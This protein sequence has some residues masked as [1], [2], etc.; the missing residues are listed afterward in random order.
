MLEIEIIL[1]EGINDKRN[2]HQCILPY[3]LYVCDNDSSC[4]LFLYIG[5]NEYKDTIQCII[6]DTLN[7]CD[8]DSSC[9][10]ITGACW[11]QGMYVYKQ[12]I[13]KVD[14]VAYFGMP[15]NIDKDGFIR[16]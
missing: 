12:L 5:V 13:E 7:V 11:V 6:P 16:G 1:Y 4:I 10:F 2:G 9:D 8:N 3:T 15:L 14:K